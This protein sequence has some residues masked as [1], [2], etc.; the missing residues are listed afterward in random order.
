MNV[1]K[2][3]K[4]ISREQLMRNGLERIAALFAQ[5]DDFAS[6]SERLFGDAAPLVKDNKRAVS[7]F[8]HGSANDAFFAD[9]HPV[10]GDR[11]PINRFHRPFFEQFG[12]ALIE[13]S[14]GRA[15]QNCFLAAGIL[16]RSI[17]VADSCSI[18]FVVII[19]NI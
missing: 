18:I 3:G 10:F 7:Q 12:A 6:G 8:A 11:A 19:G 15:K 2:D 16:N 1:Y 5:L 17:C 13:Q 4:K 14:E 9:A